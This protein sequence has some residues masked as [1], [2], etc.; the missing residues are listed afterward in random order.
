MEW[1]LLECLNQREIVCLK[2][3]REHLLNKSESL[4]CQRVEIEISRLY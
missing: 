1:M 4:K 3:K 2:V